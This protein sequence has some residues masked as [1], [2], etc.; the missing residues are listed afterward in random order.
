MKLKI[1]G[2]VQGVGFRPVVYK[3][4][5]TLDLKGYVLNNGSGV[6]I[7]VVGINEDKFI[8]ELLS[9]LPPLAKIDNIQTFQSH[10]NYHNFEIKKSKNSTKTTSI[11]PDIAI[12]DE[13]IKDMF[14]KNN[15]RYLYPFINCTN[16]GPRYTI[17]K[18]IPYDRK[19][20]SM[21]KFKMCES[22]EKEY[23]DINSR[24]FH[25]Q[26]ISCE[27]SELKLNHSIKY[28]VEKIK[29]GKIVAIKGIGGFHLVC[30][31][32]NEIAIQTLRNRKN[33]PNKPLAMMFKNLTILE[34][35]CDLNQQDKILITSKEKPIVIVKKK[36]ELIGIAD[37]VDRY[38]VFLP[39][40]PIQLL[41]F[42]YIDFP[43]VM[44]SAN[45]SG[46]PIIRDITELQDKLGNIYDEVLDYNRDIINSCDD[47]V[48]MS[49]NE[50]KII[51]RTAR[52]YAP[53]NFFID[54]KVKPKILAVGAN[55][56]STISI[57]FDN[58]IITSPHI[59]DLNTIDSVEYFDRT[60]RT[61]R[62]FY[63]FKEDIIVCDKHPTYESTKWAINQNK[64][65]IK[66]QHHYSHILSTMFEFNLEGDYLCFCFDGTGYGDDGNI[67]GGEV[68]IANQKEY[69]RIY[70]FNYFKMIGGEKAVKNPKNMAINLQTKKF[71]K[72]PAPL[73]SSV[74]RLFDIIGYLGGFIETNSYEGE[75]GMKI[76]S[77]YNPQIKENYNFNLDNGIIDFM[78]MID[79]LDSDKEL[80]A[81]KFINSLVDVIDR[82]SDEVDLPIILSGGVFQNKTLLQQV[83]KLN[84]KI[85]FNQSTPINDGGISIGQI[86]SII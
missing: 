33:R 6:E 67:W 48:V 52:G 44:T 45:L 74:G 85:Y 65:I 72:L 21:S 76:E 28:I 25:A 23:K 42:E 36:K 17:I 14:D 38:G 4:A 81:S 11:S 51:L 32:T 39:Y 7:E 77:F 69:K 68:F 56:K 15:K 26:P 63:S 73:T 54:K 10:K 19:N 78:P 40:T 43:L 61:F 60:I 55:Q 9:N 34:E 2:I 27:K 46:E 24:F 75:S 13:C 41:L 31:A 84:K 22:C 83:L 20:T 71:D 50:T 66:I 62:K 57:A 35:Y 5:K 29:D 59:G 8:D 86:K 1:T 64:E 47:S 80:I 12:C 53:T 3:I 58:K 30:D 16:C 37:G 18:N 49:V 70:H 82:I 79:N